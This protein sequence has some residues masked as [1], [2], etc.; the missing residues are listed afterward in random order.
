ML[1]ADAVHQSG[2][3]L[4]NFGGFIDGTVRPVCGP[5]V[6]V[7]CNGHK[8]VHSIKFK[9][10][11]LPNELVGHLYGPVGG[12]RHDSSMLASSGFYKSCKDSLIPQ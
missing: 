4:D 1:Y 7:L 6:R 5:D 10:V 12:R 8:R 3:A 2:A 9:S 11:A